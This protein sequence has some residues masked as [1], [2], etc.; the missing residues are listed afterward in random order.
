MQYQRIERN[1][2]SKHKLIQEDEELFSY[3]A[4]NYTSDNEREFFEKMKYKQ[5]NVLT[6]SNDLILWEMDNTDHIYIIR[7]EYEEYIIGHGVEGNYDDEYHSMT[8]REALDVN[9]K[10][11]GFIDQDITLLDWLRARDYQGI[12]Y[13]HNYDDL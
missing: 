1:I 7:C 13:D 9:L 3:M 2:M 4:K 10:A 6:I 11:Q 12:Q 5:E 8:L